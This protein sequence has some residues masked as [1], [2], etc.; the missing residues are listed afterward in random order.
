[1]CC[2]Q[3]FR[4]MNRIMLILPP[5]EVHIWYAQESTL[6]PGMEATLSA[7]ERA[8]AERFYFPQHRLSYV[9]AHGVLRD[10]LSRYLHCSRE[11]I[12]FVENEFGKPLLDNRDEG[13]A[14]EFNMA[15]SGG[16]VVVSL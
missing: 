6:P 14:L 5:E 8:R 16:L 7:D 9:F 15:H 2:R 3:T 1:M 12:R 13:T 10:V 11:A 4:H